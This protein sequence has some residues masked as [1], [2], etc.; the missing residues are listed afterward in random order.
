MKPNHLAGLTRMFQGMTIYHDAMRRYIGREMRR[1]IGDDW[2]STRVID[3]IKDPERKKELPQRLDRYRST[4]GWEEGLI[5]VRD[6]P[7]IISAPENSNVFSPELRQLEDQMNYLHGWRKV[8]AH[9]TMDDFIPQPARKVPDICALVLQLVK[10]EAAAEQVRR[11]PEDPQEDLQQLEQQLE[12][13]LENQTAPQGGRMTRHFRRQEKR[14]RQELDAEHEKTKQELDAEHEKTKQELDA[15]QEAHK[16]TKQEL[17]AEQ[18]AH[19]KTKQELEAEQEAHEKTKQELEAVNQKL[20]KVIN[21]GNS[22]KMKR[23][24]E[25]EDVKRELIRCRE[26]QTAGRAG[27]AAVGGCTAGTHASST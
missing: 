20:T 5:E 14:V 9:P 21:F 3:I 27:T 11:L 2:F 17:E 18:E 16:K 13:A 25:L 4:S 15:E 10:N 12:A 24:R 22:F 23:D 19:K 26:R 6:I 1:K 8:W 7:E